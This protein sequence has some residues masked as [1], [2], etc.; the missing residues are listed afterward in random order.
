MKILSNAFLIVYRVV[1]TP[2]HIAIATL[3]AIVFRQSWYEFIEE[4]K[5]FYK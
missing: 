5:L 3:N 1:G 4:I 2:F